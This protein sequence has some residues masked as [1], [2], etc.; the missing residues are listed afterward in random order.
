[1]KKLK[2]VGWAVL[3]FFCSFSLL[4]GCTIITK[5]ISYSIETDR[6]KT[7]DYDYEGVSI[8][9]YF[10]GKESKEVTIPI[11]YNKR[12]ISSPYSYNPAVYGNFDSIKNVSV[13]LIINGEM[14]QKF[15]ISDEKANSDI[16]EYPGYEYRFFLG[17]T[18]LEIDH[19]SFK[20]LKVTINF[21]GIKDNESKDY[22]RTMTLMPDLK[23][24]YYNLLLYNIMY[25]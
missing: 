21:T 9:A 2:Y 18:E 19:E 8:W 24:M 4:N 7:Q 23:V 22:S 14:K 1:M 16:T 3:L 15:T 25:G 12:K 17:R 10:R 20:E 5:H 13:E 6:S 11:I